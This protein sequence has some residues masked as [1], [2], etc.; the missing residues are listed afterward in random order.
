MGR[1]RVIFP[2]VCGVFVYC[3]F[4][5]LLGPKSI[6]AAAQ[7]SLERDKVLANLESLYAV[8]ADLDAR[9]KN[10]TADPDTIAVYA[11]ELGFVSK[12]E[13]LIR[14]AGFSGGI[15]RKLYAG[16]P[17]TVQAPVFLP[18]WACKLFG[19]TAAVACMF[20]MGIRVRPKKEKP[21][22]EPI[23]EPQKSV[24]EQE[25]DYSEERSQ[26]S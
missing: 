22:Q 19:I 17:V 2:V 10:L 12:G 5:I 14:L 21:Q 25:D 7:L 23:E 13:R 16:T 4:S 26:I 11:H 1:L 24:K 6:W 9:V 15:D 18:E 20:L 3:V 8:N